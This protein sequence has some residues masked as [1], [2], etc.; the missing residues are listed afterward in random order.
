M[1]PRPYQAPMVMTAPNGPE[2]LPSLLARVREGDETALATI[3]QHYET[4]LRLTAHALIGPALRT[5]VDTV[6]LVQSVHRALMPGLRE[7]KYEL[8][9]SEQLLSLA[10]TVIR[11]K[12]ITKWRRLHP[13]HERRQGD[14]TTAAQS[15]G[16]EDDPSL[17]AQVN[18]SVRHLLD[19]LPEADRQLLELRVQG[20]STVEIADRLQCEAPA[21]RAR[22]SRLRQRLRELGLGDSL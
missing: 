7:G 1:V 19:S 18:D 15:H 20:Y 12:V 14:A 13:E 21:L 17:V 6:D 16:R 5:Q 9:D 8:T 3:L 4:R 22:L 10:L 11:N 2:T